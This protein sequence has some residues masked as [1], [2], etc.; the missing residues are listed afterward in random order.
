MNPPLYSAR[1]QAALPQRRNWHH[2]N[3]SRSYFGTLTFGFSSPWPARPPTERPRGRRAAAQ[4]P[5][6]R[7]GRSWGGRIPPSSRCCA[8]LRPACCW[9]A[10]RQRV[11]L[12]EQRCALCVSTDPPARVEG[13]MRLGWSSPDA[14]HA[15]EPCLRH[16]ERLD[17]ATATLFRFLR[18]WVVRFA[19]ALAVP[20]LQR[21]LLQLF[22]GM[23]TSTLRLRSCRISDAVGQLR[24]VCQ[25]PGGNRLHEMGLVHAHLLGEFSSQLLWYVR[26]LPSRR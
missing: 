3:R 20:R 26:S 10:A 25:L 1:G 16:W 17:S 21:V 12:D 5:G 6:F 9:P 13:A 19:A 15:A 14:W 2:G 8:P 24:F 11:Q 22:T 7:P 18:Q 4:A 23:L